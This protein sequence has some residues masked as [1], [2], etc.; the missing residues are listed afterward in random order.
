MVNA[1]TKHLNVSSADPLYKVKQ[2]ECYRQRLTIMTVRCSKL[3]KKMRELY[4]QNI[5]IQNLLKMNK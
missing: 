4:R 3:R 1:T 2:L 5:E